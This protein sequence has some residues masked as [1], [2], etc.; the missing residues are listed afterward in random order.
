[1]LPKVGSVVRL[2]GAVMNVG[3]L[4]SR[5]RGVAVFAAGA[6][7][8]AI[9]I[10]GG[11]AI[12]SIPSTTTGAITACVKSAGGAVRIIDAQAGHHC[13]TGETAV[14]WSK[15]YTYRGVW[16][17][18]TPYRVLDVVTSGGASYLAKAP[19]TGSNPATHPTLWGVLAARGAT[20]PQGPTGPPGPA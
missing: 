20:G 6:L 2:R 13:V 18:A 5:R 17:A 11:A 14:T 9:A 15:G 10:G 4:A 12:A 3:K 8:A 16:S 7:S 19:S 1:M